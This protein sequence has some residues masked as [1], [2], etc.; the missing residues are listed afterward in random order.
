MFV[1]GMKIIMADGS[2]MKVEEV[3][4]GDKIL[5]KDLGAVGVIA[6][7][8]G[9]EESCIYI[10]L[11]NKKNISVSFDQKLLTASGIVEAKKLAVGDSLVLKDMSYAIIDS[12]NVQEN[13]KKTY[14][15]Y[16]ENKNIFINV[17]G[18]WVSSDINW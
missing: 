3:L 8:D 13:N 14:G 12:I 16:L 6:G 18:I 7:I 11:A 1:E 2:M 4:S 10:K 17:N 15:F 5:T 9:V